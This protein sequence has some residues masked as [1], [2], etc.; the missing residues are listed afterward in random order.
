MK[1][2]FPHANQAPG[3]WSAYA[4]P[5]DPLIES[6]ELLG[7]KWI[8]PEAGVGTIFDSKGNMQTLM[9]PTYVSAY[10]ALNL[11]LYPWIYYT[12]HSAMA[13]LS[14][15]S[16]LLD[17][18]IDGLI[19]DVETEWQG[20][21]AG[22]AKAFVDR[23]RK[24]VGSNTFVG[25][26]SFDIPLW[27]GNFPWS[28]FCALD[29]NFPQLYAYEHDDQGYVHWS[30]IYDRQWKIMDSHLDVAACPRYP[31]GCNYRPAKRGGKVLGPFDNV[32]LAKDIAS[33]NSKMTGGWYTIEMI[34]DGPHE[35][36][37][38]MLPG[39]PLSVPPPFCP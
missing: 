7:A 23:V 22:T 16:K 5:V 30:D 25:F 12:P 36:Y 26:S 3:Y 37:E 38:A 33:A 32:K 34:M 24:V 8:A 15:L 17:L 10:R 39:G 14:Y 18:G 20:V 4:K 28:E 29:A 31:I 27:H 6:L 1:N 9:T 21:P 35:V 2:V 19:L 13:D 11:G